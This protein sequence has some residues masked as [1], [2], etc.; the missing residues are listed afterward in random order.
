MDA[1]LEKLHIL[2]REAKARQTNPS[3]KPSIHLHTPII[4]PLSAQ[5]TP[6]SRS[7]EFPSSLFL[8]KWLSP[9][10]SPSLPCP[11]LP[12]P[13][14]KESPDLDH[15]ARSQDTCV[16][17]QH[18]ASARGKS[19]TSGWLT[20]RSISAQS[21]RLISS[22]TG[23]CC[24]R[25]LQQSCV[26]VPGMIFTPQRTSPERNPFFLGPT[27]NTHPQSRRGS[28][29][30]LPSGRR[31]K[32]ANFL[33]PVPPCWINHRLPTL[34]KSPRRCEPVKEAPSRFLW[35][36][37]PQPLDHLGSGLQLSFAPDSTAGPRPSHTKGD[38]L[39]RA[40]HAMAGGNIPGPIVS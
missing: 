29:G 5:C 38:E 11:L 35:S 26:P 27:P 12:V 21:A 28:L 7:S 36:P 32:K 39:V 2:D 15:E 20:A 9:A 19:W 33:T 1:E 8:G 25:C 16:D 10:T 17:A 13:S 14:W 40:L 18:V 24:P 4:S 22:R 6:R 30:P 34:R 3:A 31:V 37:S 23:Q